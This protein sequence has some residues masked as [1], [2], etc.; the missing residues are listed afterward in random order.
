M[1]T[2]TNQALPQSLWRVHRYALCKYTKL[3]M[4]MYIFNEVKVGSHFLPMYC[5]S[6][7]PLCAVRKNTWS[8]LSIAIL[9]LNYI[10]WVC[11][12]WTVIRKLSFMM[13]IIIIILQF[14]IDYQWNEVK[15]TCALVINRHWVFKYFFL[16][17]FVDSVET[18]SNWRNS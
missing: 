18:N 5:K 13:I 6:L 2:V 12:L 17:L 11:F 8:F 16:I 15:S 7:H 1:V 3:N 14:S 4:R 9:L 10:I